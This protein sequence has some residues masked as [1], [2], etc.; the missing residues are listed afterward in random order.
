VIRHA[1]EAIK[2]SNTTRLA[3]LVL[4]DLE[5]AAYGAP[6]MPFDAAPFALDGAL[7]LYPGSGVPARTVVSSVPRGAPVTLVVPDGNWSQTRRMVRR[8]C[9]R[10]TLRRLSIELPTD[11][12]SAHPRMR[13]VG[14]RPDASCSTIEALAEALAL[15]E[16]ERGD[17]IRAALRGAYEQ[18]VRA[19]LSSRG[20]TA[21]NPAQN[22]GGAES[23]L[24]RC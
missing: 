10:M 8:L 21:R 12:R 1:L 17:T 22:V 16:G 3:A 13:A 20:H 23:G 14:D 11:S 4:E 5:I 15:L 6:G 19:T 9:D 2:P 24:T 18:M 7:L